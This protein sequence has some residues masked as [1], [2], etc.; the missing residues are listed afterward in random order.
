MADDSITAEGWTRSERPANLHR[1]FEFA[2]YGETRGFLD[3]L[4]ALSKETGRYPDISFG[5]R[6]ANVTIHAGDDSALG[7]EELAFAS[8][9]NGLVAGAQP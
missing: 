3:R 1:R 8:R 5:T 9:A 6:Y 2:A 4:A 7:A